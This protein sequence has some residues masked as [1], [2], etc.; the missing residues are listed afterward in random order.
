[1]KIKAALLLCLMSAAAFSFSGAYRSL[2]RVTGPVLPEE[3]AARFV[4]RGES[5]ETVLEAGD[6][7]SAF[8]DRL[9]RGFLT[10]CAAY[11]VFICFLSGIHV[12][13][14]GP[15]RKA[16]A[17][18]VG[19]TVVL[20]LLVRSFGLEPLVCAVKGPDPLPGSHGGF[21][22]EQLAGHG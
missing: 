12:G 6:A 14:A 2:H 5:A 22:P 21:P 19:I 9:A 3:V 1:M 16:T 15:V 10:G 18:L 17:L 8:T 4:G 7:G 13:G 11:I 20:R